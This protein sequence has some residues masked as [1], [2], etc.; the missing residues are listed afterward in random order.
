MFPF[1]GG[2][3]HGNQKIPTSPIDSNAQ[4]EVTKLEGEVEA[5]KKELDKSEADQAA[6]PAA[7]ARTAQDVAGEI[8]Q[9]DQDLSKLTDRNA[10]GSALTGAERRGRAAYGPA[11]EA[12]CAPTRGRHLC[13]AY[14]GSPSQLAQPFALST[15]RRQ[16][17]IIVPR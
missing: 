7:P 2:P 16:D 14:D 13:R 12:V 17:S 9:I 4:G 15:A 10:G 5:L 6:E 1:R 3:L 11:G 8:E